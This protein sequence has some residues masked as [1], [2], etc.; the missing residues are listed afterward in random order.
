MTAQRQQK[1]GTVRVG[2]FLDKMIIDANIKTE[3]FL[4][5]LKENNINDI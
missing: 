4:I 2:L 3:E 1:D 5:S